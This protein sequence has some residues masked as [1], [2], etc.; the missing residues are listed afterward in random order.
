MLKRRKKTCPCHR[1]HIAEAT[2]TGAFSLLTSLQ[3]SQTER[4]RVKCRGRCVCVCVGCWWSIRGLKSSQMWAYPQMIASL[5]LLLLLSNCSKM[6][7][8]FFSSTVWNTWSP[9]FSK[10]W[11]SHRAWAAWSYL[12]LYFWYLFRMKKGGSE[13]YSHQGLTIPFL[14]AHS[15]QYIKRQSI[16]SLTI[17]LIDK[18]LKLK[19]I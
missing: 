11:L 7:L 4:R 19:E 17:T 3:R 9:G 5:L 14:L 2:L 12:L 6:W 15:G 1:F 16:S 13:Q 8:F 18:G 10:T